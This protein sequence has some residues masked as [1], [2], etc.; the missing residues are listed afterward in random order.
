MPRRKKL[1]QQ[2]KFNERRDNKLWIGAA[3][4]G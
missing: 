4:R 1:S 3:G 2:L